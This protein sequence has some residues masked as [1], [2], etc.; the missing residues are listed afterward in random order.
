MLKGAAVRSSP[1]PKNT[2]H[3]PAA[4][5]LMDAAALTL[6]IDGMTCQACAS[7]I[8]KVL[9]KKSAIIQ[10]DVNYA[11]E[12]AQIR[13]DAA[14]TNPDT[15]IEW[16]GK[17]GYHAQVET[18]VLA[19]SDDVADSTKPP[20]RL[21]ITWLCL[22]PFLVGM[23]GMLVGWHGA[24]LPVAWQFV[25]ASVV[26]FGTALPLYRSAWASVRGGLANMDVLV[27][28]ATLTIWL[29]SIYLWQ[30][31]PAHGVY[32]EASVMVIGF[33]QL[34]KYLEQRTKKTSLNSINLL[35]TLTPTQVQVKQA[36]GSWQ[37]Q[38]VTDLRCGQVVLASTGTRIAA[39]GQVVAGAGWCDE[40]HLTGE[41]LP[42][43]KDTGSRVLAGALVTD[44]SVE[45]RV[46]ATG[47]ATQLGD[48]IQAL[49]DAQG[50]K[51]NMARLADKVSAVFVPVV[52][53]LALLCWLVNRMAG[54][55][56]DD[57]LLRAVSVLVIACP[58]ALGLA[59]PAAIMAGMG[60]AARHGV[61][62]KDAQ[63]LEAAGGIDTLVLDKTGTLTQGTPQVIAEYQAANL[64]ATGLDHAALLHLVGDIEQRTNHPFA[65]ALT[66]FSQQ[67]LTDFS[68]ETR[69][70]LSQDF[71]LTNVQTVAGHG[72]QAHVSQHS[73]GKDF[74]INIGSPTW[75]GLTL[76]ETIGLASA[77]QI[78]SQVAVSVDGVPVAAFALA[79]ALKPEAEQALADWQGMGLGVWLLS[80]DKPSVVQHIADELH[81]DPNHACGDLR[82]TDKADRIRA[83]Q[84]QG[85]RVAM[86]GDGINDAP[87]LAVADASFAVAHATDIANH[88]AAARLL[89]GGLQQLTAALQIARATL[90]TIR[91]NLFF[92][93][94]YNAIGMALAAFGL[95]NP[96]IAAAA[97]AMSSLSVLFNAIRLNRWHAPSASHLMPADTR[98]IA[99]KSAPTVV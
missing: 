12:Q 51:A 59:T 10:A 60:V 66:A 35:L 8:E 86:V 85:Q 36:D 25:L 48:L 50:S 75:V 97:M 46:R 53:G 55:T 27:V 73:T 84:A 56:A 26:Q 74:A 68:A 90:R 44:G 52:V 91:Q 58:C 30:V 38:D 62:F 40:S 93:F 13:Y 77:W 82:P 9:N 87:A 81:L 89:G 76:P 83:L 19:A 69:Q 88:S 4:D 79:D 98:M 43:K 92:A 64:V 29:Y 70:T 21:M 15:I 2:T 7:R 57:A 80:G 6:T 37:V 33:V 49:H 1:T 11:N 3:S 96:M 45:Y 23:L 67:Q 61:W 71:S 95:L 17:A 54:V 16:I 28:L 78:A 5:A 22:A 47:Q 32:F 20:L 99:D 39:D 41:S 18:S 42:V 63:A 31:T 24:M 34:G 72:V 14:V 65:R 94:I